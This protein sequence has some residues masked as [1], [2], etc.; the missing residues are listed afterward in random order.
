MGPNF[1]YLD[2]VGVFGNLSDNCS[3]EV[4]VLVVVVG[5]GGVL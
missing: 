5:R 4:A 2:R 3:E 1:E